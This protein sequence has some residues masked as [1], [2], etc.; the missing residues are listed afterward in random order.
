MRKIRELLRL[1]H[2]G[3]SQRQ[4]ASS[5]SVA[6]GT[7]C[8]QLKRAQEVGMTW[9]RAEKLTD[10]ELEALMFRGMRFTE[11]CSYEVE[12]ASRLGREDGALR[13]SEFSAGASSSCRAVRA[14]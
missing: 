11:P 8:G 12:P 2:S 14:G 5:L 13:R 10:A 3:R 6:V 4:I 9:E 7:V 1:K